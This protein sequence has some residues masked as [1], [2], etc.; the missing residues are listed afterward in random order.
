MDILEYSGLDFDHLSGQVNIMIN[1]S[2]GTFL[3]ELRRNDIVVI[4][5]EG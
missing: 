5:C 4:A 3:Q 2:N 1:G